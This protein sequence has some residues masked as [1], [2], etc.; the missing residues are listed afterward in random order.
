MS[1]AAAVCLLSAVAV[2]C[3]QPAPEPAPEPT[4]TPPAARAGV[5]EIVQKMVE[6]HGG[7]APWHNAPSVSFESAIQFAQAEGPLVSRV[8]VEQGRRRLYMDFPGTEMRLAWDGEKAWSENWALPMPPRFY[9]NLQY[10]FL[11]LPWLAL[12]PG[13]N[14]ERTGPARLADDPTEYVE[15]KMTFDAGV[16]DT[17]DDYYALLIDPESGRLAGTRYIVTYEAILPEGVERSPEQTLV[18]DEMT[19]VDGL[20]VPTGYTVYA[21]DGSVYATCTARDWS[22]R[23]PFDESFLEMPETGAVD[24]STP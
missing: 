1:R 17:P 22:F 20:V 21:P 12:D 3:A 11:N 18:Y 16:G 9:A 19:T 5:P 2:G 8:T 4:P 24:E 23:E 6:A 10:Y 15:V 14:L 13:V 7:L